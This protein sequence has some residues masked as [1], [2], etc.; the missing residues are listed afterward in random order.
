MFL[1]WRKRQT[2]R[3][4]KNMEYL[5]IF[6]LSA[7]LVE[8]HRVN[9]KPRQKV[10]RY[11]GSI[12]ERYAK[13]DDDGEDVYLD[14]RFKFWSTVTDNLDF[15][16]SK[17]EGFTQEDVDAFKAKISERVDPISYFM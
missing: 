9:G 14:E 17:R 16:I 1:K 10:I 12:A 11:L 7:E 13:E 8:S 5:P 4:N 15:L 2:I 3:M 6:Y